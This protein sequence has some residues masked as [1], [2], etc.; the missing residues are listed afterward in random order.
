MA[1]EQQDDGS[2]E[3]PDTG[4]KVGQWNELIGEDIEYKVSCVVRRKQVTSKFWCGLEACEC[5]GQDWT[6]CVELGG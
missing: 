5:C 3:Q 4:F 1:A 2:Q 6:A